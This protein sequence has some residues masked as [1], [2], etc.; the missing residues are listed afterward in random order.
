MPTKP[1]PP[2]TEEPLRT[3]PAPPTTAPLQ[4]TQ[5]G[6]LGSVH[7]S[8]NGFVVR[9]GIDRERYILKPTVANYNAMFS[10]LLACWL[11]RGKLSIKYRNRVVIS[12]EDSAFNIE[13][14]D[15]LPPGSEGS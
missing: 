10:L 8:A 11:D 4:T 12:D 1:T 2:T 6:Y 13:G 14:I 9:I 7:A 15:A 5:W 3:T